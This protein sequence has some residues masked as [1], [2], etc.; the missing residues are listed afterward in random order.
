[1]WVSLDVGSFFDVGFFGCGFF[2][3]LI[4][5]IMVIKIH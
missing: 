1:M 5:K 3:I 2:F 4:S